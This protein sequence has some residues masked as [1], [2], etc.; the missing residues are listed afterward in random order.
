MIR[1]LAGY[2]HVFPLFTAPCNLRRRDRD[3]DFDPAR[4]MIQITAIAREM[5]TAP[6]ASPKSIAARARLHCPIRFNRIDKGSIGYGARDPGEK[7]KK[8]MRPFA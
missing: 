3:K 8:F 5:A 1:R 2:T 6:A 4:R 7:L